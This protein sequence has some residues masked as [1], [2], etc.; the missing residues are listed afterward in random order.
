[1]GFLNRLFGRSLVAMILL[2]L[3]G[4]TFAG[5]S[6][7]GIGR[8]LQVNENLYRGAQ[9]SDPG[10]KYLAK[11]GVKTV[12]DLREHDERSAAEE[13]VVTGLGMR[14]VNV[15]MGGLT[16]PTEAQTIQVLRLLE[17]SSNGPVFVHCRQ[18][19]DR[20]GAVIGAYRIDHDHW[21]NAEAL[22]EARAIGMSFFQIPRQNYLRSFR[23]RTADGKVLLAGGER[24]GPASALPA[25]AAAAVALPAT[26]A[27]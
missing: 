1:M 15:P 19:K 23:A 3:P 5:S 6:A 22:K 20:T 13:R 16:P 14:Y 4:L 17:D 21:E 12:L 25:P 7:G 9:P 8:F 2:G 27:P 18:G 24:Q 11:I 26:S 10:F